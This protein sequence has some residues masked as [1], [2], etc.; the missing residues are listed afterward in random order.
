[1]TGFSLSLLLRLRHDYGSGVP[2]HFQREGVRGL[3]RLQSSCPPRS[4][5]LPLVSDADN[6]W[7]ETGETAERI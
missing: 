6:V 4:C 3:S 2:P 1:V 5:G 7:E